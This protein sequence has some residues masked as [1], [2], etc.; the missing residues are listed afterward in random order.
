MPSSVDR[1]QARPCRLC[2][3]ALT[4]LERLQGDVCRRIDCRRQAT[5][6]RALLK[7]DAL[8][9]RRRAAARLAWQE[10]TVTEAPV[11]W[12]E[13]HEA[14]L[15]P[16]APAHREAHRGYLEGLVPELDAKDPMPPGTLLPKSADE[17]TPLG[18]SLC[19][20]CAGRCCR[21]GADRHAFIT[22]ELLGRWLA[23]HPGS[24][25]ADAV[26]A[27]FALL[28]RRH[29]A[30][31]CVHHGRDGCTLPAP[32]R[33]DVCNRYAC[34]ALR[35]VQDAGDAPALVAAMEQHET[36][37]EAALLW[38]GGFRKLPRRPAERRS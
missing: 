35:A 21:Y 9:A 23:R 26:A 33:S 31:S 28:P 38:P 3:A 30:G 17:S 4:P 12:L 19:A 6:E 20:F 22:A 27:Y 14:G 1:W 15:V 18:R 24:A 13:R 10:P 16:L 34:N 32:M 37:G 8:L 29:V 25:P 11:V 2:G 5:R 36:L 7:R